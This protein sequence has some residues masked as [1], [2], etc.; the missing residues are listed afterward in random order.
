M[1]SIKLL[2]IWLILSISTINCTFQFIQKK[3]R[4]TWPNDD[5]FLNSN[6]IEAKKSELSIRNKIEAL[7]VVRK[8]ALQIIAQR[9]KQNYWNPELA[10]SLRRG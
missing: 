1:F 6:F 7:D 8:L 4:V 5:I 3:E 9:I 10:A 2:S